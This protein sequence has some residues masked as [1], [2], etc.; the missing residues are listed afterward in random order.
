[1]V[2]L[3]HADY[4]TVGAAAS[5]LDR[6]LAGQSD[7]CGLGHESFQHVVMC[8]L[9]L[10]C[11]MHQTDA[12]AV[13][14]KAMSLASS[15]KLAA[16]DMARLEVSISAQLGWY[17]NPPTPAVLIHNLLAFLPLK[18]NLTFTHL[19]ETKANELALLAIEGK[20]SSQQTPM[21]HI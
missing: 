16:Q 7:V 1:M 3:F 13:M 6:Y 17:L 8:A 19:V 12:S 9:S 18:S 20:C 15:A 21:A 11:K 14:A 5:I 2:K 4:E 10:A